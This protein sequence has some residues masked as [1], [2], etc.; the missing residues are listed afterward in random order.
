MKNPAQLAL[1]GLKWCFLDQSACVEGC[2][3]QVELLPGRCS[4]CP[5]ELFLGRT[6]DFTVEQGDAVLQAERTLD[7]IAEGFRQVVPTRCGAVDVEAIEADLAPFRR[8]LVAA[9]LAVVDGALQKKPGGHLHQAGRQ[10]HRLGSIK[11]RGLARQNLGA[12]RPGPSR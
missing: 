12:A 9:H 2:A 4:R 10:A 8:S 6:I 7:E 3:Q 11:H 5:L 1:A